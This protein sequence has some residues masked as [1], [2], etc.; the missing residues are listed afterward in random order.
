MKILLLGA[1]GNVG[2]EFLK[3]SQEFNDL[4]FI[5]WDK[6][7]ID[8]T[9]QSLLEKKI[10]ELKPEVIINTVGYSKVDECEE[11][12]EAAQQAFLL[13]ERVVEFLAEIALE[14]NCLLVHYSSDYVFS[15][16]TSEG[17]DE[18]AEPSPLNVYGESKRA[19]ELALQRLSGRGLRWYLIRTA[20]LFGAPG[21]GATAKQSFFELILKRAQNHSPLSLVTDERGSFTYIPDLISATVSLLESNE[22]FGVYHFIN[23]GSASWY[24]AASYFFKKMNLQPTLVPVTREEFS[25]PAKRPTDSHL[26]NT[27]RPP[28]RTWQAAVDEYCKTL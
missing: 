13:N 4:S 21:E 28:L 14:Y 11:N 24:E 8:V 1:K 15:G 12:E 16:Q 27:K 9:D 22:G 25:R 26:R 2:T 23:E 17:Y 19:G 5:G 20:R 10:S 6:D 18:K 3:Q 7:D